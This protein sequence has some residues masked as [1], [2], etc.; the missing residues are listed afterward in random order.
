MAQAALAE[1][2]CQGASDAAPEHAFLE[3]GGLAAMPQFSQMAAAEVVGVFLEGGQGQIVLAAL[4]VPLFR[5]LIAQR[6]RM[7]AAAPGDHLDQQAVQA[8]SLFR[9]ICGAHNQERRRHRVP[10]LLL[11]LQLPP[12]AQLPRA[13]TAALALMLFAPPAP[14]HLYMALPLVN[15]ALVGTSALL[16]PLH[17]LALI[18]AEATTAPTALA[19][20]R[21]ALFKCLQLAD[22]VPYKSKALHSSRK[23]VTALTTAS[24]TLRQA[25][26]Y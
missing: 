8:A 3:G 11:A 14:S 24:G 21:P 15:N 20:Q 26:A 7:A 23:Q 5:F 1:H 16:A 25:T 22:G 2:R 10:L 13:I 18:A 4:E 12:P 17:G 19:L 6:A 9:Q